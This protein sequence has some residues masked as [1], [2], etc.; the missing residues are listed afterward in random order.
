FSSRRR[1]TIFSR[2]WSSDV[3]SSDL[4]DGRLQPRPL[5]RHEHALIV[6]PA[7]VARRLVHARDRRGAPVARE[8]RDRL[9][10]AF[11][12]RLEPVV[13]RVHRD[14]TQPALEQ[15]DRGQ[16]VAALIRRL[17]EVRR[18]RREAQDDEREHRERDNDLDQRESVLPHQKPLCQALPSWKNQL[19]RPVD[20]ST[21]T[22]RASRA[23]GVPVAVRYSPPVSLALPLRWNVT[24][25]VPNRCLNVT[26]A[27]PIGRAGAGPRPNTTPS[28]NS[29]AVTG[30]FAWTTP[31]LFLSSWT[32]S[33]R[34][35]TSNQTMTSCWGSTAR[36]CARANVEETSRTAS[37]MR[38]RLMST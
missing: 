29:T 33:R 17:G 23:T 30:S 1:H 9:L 26:G 13:V 10:D 2:D 19:A 38:N 8:A 21:S 31:S 4:T 11:V 5:H 27:S 14:L 28:G 15:L 34:G 12:P 37:F 7:A 24:Y 25:G 6:E 3:C 22:A 35:V 16:P 32:R 20:R 18:G 36:Y